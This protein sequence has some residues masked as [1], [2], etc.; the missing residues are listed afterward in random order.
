MKVIVWTVIKNYRGFIGHTK[1]WISNTM[2]CASIFTCTITMISN[3]L[4]IYNLYTFLR[5][6]IHKYNI[7]LHLDMILHNGHIF[8]D[9]PSIRRRNSTW[10]VHRNYI[11]FERRIHV[12]IMTSI[13]HGNFDVDSTFKIDEISMGSSRGFFYVISTSNRS[14]FCTRCFHCIIL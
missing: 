13:R 7:L 14:N 9:L 3:F 4:I 2:G 11:D 6:F 10:K 12:E 8:V 1:F 5:L